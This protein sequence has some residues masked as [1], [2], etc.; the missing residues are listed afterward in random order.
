MPEDRDTGARWVELLSVRW[1]V[2]TDSEVRKA[3]ADLYRESVATA[4]AE[5]REQRANDKVQSDAHYL[6]EILPDVPVLVIA[7]AVGHQPNIPV[8]VPGFYGSVIPAIW[9]FQLALRSRGLGSAYTSSLNRKDVEVAELLGVP[10]GFTQ[11]AMIPV[12]HTIGSEFRPAPRPP[13]TEVTYIN[14][15]G[16][17]EATSSRVASS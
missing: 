4:M 11:V 12:G 13:I 15:W 14:R 6:A 16:G 10:D 1:L 3:V 9:S 5:P 2:V 7:Y 8:G 17:D